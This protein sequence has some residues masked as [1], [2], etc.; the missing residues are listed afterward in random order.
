MRI[1][2]K[3]DVKE[4]VRQP[5][6]E[7]V[8]ELIGASGGAGG[9]SKHSFALVIIPSGKSSVNHHHLVS[10]ETY[11]ILRGTAR[12][13]VDGQAFVLTPGQA[14][15]I[16]HP[17]WHQIFNVGDDDLEFIAVCAPPWTPDDSVFA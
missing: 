4:P 11:Y 7:T 10:E 14:C 8:Y 16:Q 13:V 12:M 15:L 1:A 6:G 9:A 2:S 5:Q 3:R 17:E